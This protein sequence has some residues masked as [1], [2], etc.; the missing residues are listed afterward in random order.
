M[1]K[2]VFDEIAQKALE[3]MRWKEKNL[4]LTGKAGTGKS[5]LLK[6]FLE[7]SDKTLAVLAPTG[8]AALN[9]NGTTIH[10]FFKFP[11]S[12]NEKK[13]AQMWKRNRDNETYTKLETIIIDEISMV[14]AD[15]F[16]MINR[17]L[18][19][20]RENIYPFGGVQMILIWDLYQLPPVVMTKEK[21]LFK[22]VYNSPYF[23]DSHISH[24]GHFDL[25]FIELEKIYR[26]SDN[27]FISILNAIRNKTLDDENLD[28]LN[29]NVK[30]NIKPQAGII[31]I[32]SRNIT[33]DETNIKHLNELDWAPMTC[34]A[35]I[36]WEISKNAFPTEE[37]LVLKEGAQ[38]MFVANDSLGRRVNG[39]L[40]IIK[41]MNDEFITVQIFDWEEVEVTP[42]T[43]K[44]IDY[45]YNKDNKS[46]DSFMVGSFTQIPLKLAWAITI[47]KSQGKTFDKVVID[48]AGWLFAPGQAYVALSRCSDLKWITLTAPLRKEHIILDKNIVDYL[49][50]WITIDKKWL[51]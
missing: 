49:N 1:K 44:V 16:D 13:A 5:T 41:E 22:E 30:K 8:V 27:K 21:Q 48:L 10:S 37:L 47:H 46:L 6:Y 2:L 28:I 50:N 32:T 23:F 11:I 42:H 4:F 9:I 29:K 17:F 18:Q 39:T 35:N 45:E 34:I 40:G 26:Q 24:T 20:A 31:N 33:A 7:D 12:I 25:E 3:I 15:L 14:R 36:N 19:E 51:F 43:W 38:V